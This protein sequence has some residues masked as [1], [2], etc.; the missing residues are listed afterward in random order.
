[1]RK[2]ILVE[3]PVLCQSGYAEHARMVLRALRSQEDVFDIYILPTMWGQSSWLFEQNEERSWIDLIINKTVVSLQRQQQFDVYI[4]VGIPPEMKRKGPISISVNAGIETDRV[5]PEWIDVLNR[6]C[7]KVITISQHSMDVY[8]NTSYGAQDQNGNPFEL[9]L[10]IPV[11]YVGYPIKQFKKF[12]NYDWIKFDYDFNFLC[13][14]QWGPRKNL[15]NTIKWFVEEFKNDKVGLVCKISGANNSLMDR[16]ACE[17]QLE[18]ILKEYPN[19][20]CKVYLLHGDMSEDEMHNLYIH[21]Q[22]K[23]MINFGHGEGYGLPLFEAAYCGLPVITHD[24]G[25]QK[26]F[27]FFE[28]D[29]KRKAGFLKLPY[30]LGQIDPQIL[31]PLSC[32][33]MKDMQWAYIKPFMAK[34][35]V[36]E[37]FKDH[38]RFK[39]QA[40]KLRESI[41]ENYQEKDINSKFIDILLGKQLLPAEEFDGISFCIPTNGKRVDKTKML[42]NSIRKQSGSNFEIIMCGDIDS[43]KDEK[44]VILIDNKEEAHTR[45]VAFLRNTAALKAKYQVIAWCDD[46]MILELDWLKKTVEFSKNNGW[47]IL[48]NKIL[49]PDGSR[50]WD[51]ATLNPHVL[52]DYDESEGNIQLYQ[53]SGFFLTRKS[54]WEKVKW[55]ETKLIHSDREGGIP[56]DIQYSIDLKKDL[57]ALHF[58]KSS[59]VWHNDNDYT[60]WGQQTFKKDGLKKS[61]NIAMFPDNDN[62]FNN[63]VELVK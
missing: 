17:T 38:G 53:T 1:M 41:L 5:K 35:G 51:R 36:R 22:I 4:H 54:I 19:R 58:N 18:E 46:D 28:K 8:K 27:L 26:D 10:N 57:K 15:G 34:S 48:G 31:Q 55:D 21:P 60:Q 44:D 7:D 33:M 25:G 12:D 61:L 13:V 42:L 14:A 37:M 56:E 40:K 9:K 59:T 29:G 52:V 63:I 11:D 49:N 16:K 45:K 62:E 3:G 24:F 23:S 6:E 43:F 50:C 39:G 2:K 30:D 47:N 20:E 32:C